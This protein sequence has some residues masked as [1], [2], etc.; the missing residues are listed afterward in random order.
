MYD[1][2]FWMNPRSANAGPNAIA[3][4]GYNDPEP[5]TD[6]PSSPLAPPADPKGF[7]WN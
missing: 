3:P 5:R 6:L 1:G 4:T 2:P 7:G